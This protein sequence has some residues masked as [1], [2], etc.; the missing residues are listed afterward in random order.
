M[1]NQ[2]RP[3]S[4]GKYK[5]EKKFQHLKLYFEK[6]HIIPVK[7]KDYQ[8]AASE[9][10]GKPFDEKFQELFDQKKRPSYFVPV[11]VPQ[12][13]QNDKTKL[14]N[15]EVY[16]NF[17]RDVELHNFYRENFKERNIQTNKNY[18]CWIDLETTTKMNVKA[19][20]KHKMFAYI[21]ACK[22]Q[23]LD[24][25]NNEPYGGIIND[26]DSW[27]FDGERCIELFLNKLK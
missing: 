8:N 1:Y 11:C 13:K 2:A 21:L 19:M 22:F 25:S 20:D 6:S 7:D 12:T 3:L 15:Q 5:V 14:K 26:G 4:L 17:E 16:E 24:R 9:N 10:C 18:F 23:C 27:V